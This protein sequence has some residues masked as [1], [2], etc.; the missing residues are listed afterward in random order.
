[1]KI[2]VGSK[3]K[4]VSGYGGDFN[5]RIATVTGV[6]NDRI[7]ATSKDGLH[8]HYDD[9]DDFHYC[10]TDGEY[11]PIPTLTIEAG[12]FYRT[13]D[14]RKVGPM[15]TYNGDGFSFR[16]G[17]RTYNSYGGYYSNGSNDLD[18]IAEWTEDDDL[19][20]I[21][22]ER[23]DGPFVKVDLAETGTLAEMNVKPGDV[24]ELVRGLTE[25][26]DGHTYTIQQNGKV[27]DNDASGGHYGYIDNPNGAIFRIISR[28]SDTFKG[29]YSFMSSDVC[30]PD[31][32][33]PYLFGDGDTVSASDSPKTWGEL[34]DA[35]KG[36][37]ALGFI[38]GKGIQCWQDGDTPEYWADIT[39]P[40]WSDDCK[41]RIKPHPKRETVALH[42]GTE[43]GKTWGFY[44]SGANDQRWTITFDTLDGTPDLDSVKMERV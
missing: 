16:C 7:M 6:M 13:R 19:N 37:I 2:E 40:N 29:D 44:T 24:V 20:E 12:K 3:V 38:Q 17:G 10:F 32:N 18:L 22:D 14:G 41:F 27:L 4:I 36:A 9:G 31:G 39:D 23:E 30:L 26:Y 35:E 8:L 25:M 28:A 5:G 1:M 43:N 21:C 33:D 15:E 42:G 11:E 34:N